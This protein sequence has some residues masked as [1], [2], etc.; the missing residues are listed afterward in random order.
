MRTTLVAVSFGLIACASAGSG[1]SS[2]T[3]TAAGAPGPEPATHAVRSPD[4]VGDGLE[5]APL[6]TNA[7]VVQGVIADVDRDAGTVSVQAGDTTRM[8]PLAAEAT[9]LIDDFRAGF[10][11]VEAGQEVRAALQET[12]GRVEAVRIEILNQGVPSDD[13]SAGA[14][15]DAAH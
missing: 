13:P 9:V 2:A 4:R 5:P 15:A 12:D 3:H 10:E 7:G 11:D 1:G 8:V 6:A 14:P